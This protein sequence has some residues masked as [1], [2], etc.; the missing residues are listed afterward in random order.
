MNIQ[1]YWYGIYLDNSSGN[2]ISGNAITASA[3][4]GILLGTSNY[5]SISGNNIANNGFGILLI[6]SSNHN[7]ISGNNLTNNEDGID[8][9]SSSNH[10]IIS[11][12][13]ITVN[14]SDT[15][16][17]YFGV[18]LHSS[19]STSISGN[20]FINSGLFCE[21]STQNSVENNTVNGMPLVYLEG[22]SNYTVDYAGQVILVKCDNITVEGFNL[23]RTTVGIEVWETSNSTISGNNI[24]ANN[25]YGI[26]LYSSLGNSISAN[27]IVANKYSGIF[28]YYS[29]NYNSISENNITDNGYDI[30]N[31]L[32][33][34]LLYSSSYNSISGNNITNNNHGIDCYFS[35]DDSFFHNNFVNNIVQASSSSGSA[36]VWDDGYPSGGNYWSD[37]NST[38]AFKGP[39]QNETGSDGIGDS[40]YSI[41]SDNTD[42]YPLMSLWV[43]LSGDVN[44]DRI[45]DIYDAILLANAYGSSSGKPNWNPNADI[46]GDNIVDIYDAILLANHFNQHSP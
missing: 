4:Q 23:S 22:V 1:R 42:R 26:Y 3:Y 5:N 6:P 35:G 12:N 31:G 29:S 9:Y 30:W 41:D 45:V 15:L 13:N 2:Y 32:D 37:Y 16:F 46:N 39:Y 27:N 19:S 8:L 28:L 10:N 38:D 18:Y 20:R 40:P 44:G 33:G 17:Y 14:P 34:I 43:R 11:G 24:T 7:T 25:T 36:N 21:N